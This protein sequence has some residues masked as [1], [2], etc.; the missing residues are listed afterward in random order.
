MSN[1]RSALLPILVVLAQVGCGDS[2]KAPAL[3][4]AANQPDA[5][6]AA[7]VTVSGKHAF[8]ANV[9][10]LVYEPATAS[11]PAVLWA[12]QNDPSKLYRL[13]WNG[14]LFTQ[15]TGEGWVTGKLLRYP[16]GTGSPDSEGVTRTDWSSNEVYVA[17]ER[18]N[19]A[20]QL[21]RQS[22]LRY[23]LTGSKG[24]LDATH[25]WQLTGDLPA[26]DVNSGLEGIAWIPD[27]YLVERG[28]VDESTQAPYVPGLYPDHGAGIFLVSVDATG[29]IYGYVLDHGA[30][31][32]FTRVVTF[33]SGQAR[34][35]D[36]TFD[37]DTGT[38]WS[39]CDSKCEDRMT[40]FEV[41]ADPASATAGRFILRA[42][43]SPPKALVD[44]NNE[45]VALAP[46]AECTGERRSIFWAD[47]GETSGYSI[48]RGS[49]VC[50][51]LY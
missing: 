1:H 5:A 18:D 30:S 20:N 27:T 14:T 3:D 40:L 22:I 36:L 47:D 15:V 43:V 23:E 37:R 12:V 39:L 8:G 7:V 42:T 34:A 33:A 6:A 31:G 19:D 11:A 35:V 38:L 41:D 21:T 13:I 16:G 44:M 46:L 9:S 45:G 2:A 32:A 48:R 4:G 10:G 17:A 50:G 24:V 49:I 28:F 29:M 26:V 25:E 51:R